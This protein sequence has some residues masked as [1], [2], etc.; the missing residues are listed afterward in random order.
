MDGERLADLFRIFFYFLEVSIY[1]VRNE[2]EWM[3]E[4]GR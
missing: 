2:G 1:V 3:S 4:S